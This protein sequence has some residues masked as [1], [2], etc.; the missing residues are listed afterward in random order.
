LDK[1]SFQENCRKLYNTKKSLK[2][3]VEIKDSLILTNTELKN[4]QTKMQSCYNFLRRKRY[5]NFDF[6]NEELDKC[7]LAIKEN[8]LSLNEINEE[9]NDEIR[10]GMLKLDD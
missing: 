9:K 8:T 7:L 6:I 4:V 10:D 1:L 3:I 2:N 5:K